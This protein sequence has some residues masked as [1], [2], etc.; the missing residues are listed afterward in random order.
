MLYGYL[1]YSCRVPNTEQIVIAFVFRIGTF[2]SALSE[3][4]NLQLIGWIQP[5][6]LF[7]PAHNAKASVGFQWRR[8]WETRKTSLLGGGERQDSR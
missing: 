7:Y 1:L 2:L 5:T 6:E 4:D 3:V 8:G